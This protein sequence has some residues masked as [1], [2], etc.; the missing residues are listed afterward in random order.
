MQRRGIFIYYRKIRWCYCDDD[1]HDFRNFVM[2]AFYISC[3]GPAISSIEIFPSVHL[4]LRRSRFLWASAFD[5]IT[6]FGSDDT[7]SPLYLIWFQTLCFIYFQCVQIFH[8]AHLYIFAAIRPHTL[9][10]IFFF[11]KWEVVFHQ[12]WLAM[13]NRPS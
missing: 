6:F 3:L 5:M 13:N 7:S 1:G 4:N 10:Q 9:L 11:Q 8:T 12:V 2:P